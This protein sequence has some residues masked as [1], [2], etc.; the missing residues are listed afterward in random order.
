FRME[1]VMARLWHGAGPDYEIE[2][3]GRNWVLK[4]DDKQPGLRV[5][6][7][8]VGP[9]LALEGG[10]AG[11]RLDCQAFSGESLLACERVVERV[12]ATYA[13][14][15]WGGL[16]VRAAWAPGEDDAINLEIQVSAQTVDELKRVEVKLASVLPEP[17]A[18]GRLRR[19]V[20]PRD[21]RSAGLSYDGR[22]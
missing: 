3:G 10:A 22:E 1:Q 20:E 6:G 18:S 8:D 14:P 17:A 7:E 19:W 9:L 12:E 13:P 5:R 2:W 15:G 21:A 4:V 11:G 16:K